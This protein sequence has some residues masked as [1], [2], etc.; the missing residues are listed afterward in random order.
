MSTEPPTEFERLKAQKDA[1]LQ[2]DNSSQFW[3][4]AQLA[5]TRL[6]E[7]L[8]QLAGSDIIKAPALAIE[9]IAELEKGQRYWFE[10]AERL[11]AELAEAKAS[12]AK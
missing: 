2:K 7:H 5:L 9:R 11:E 6:S 10:K 3:S 8:G 12:A 4:E 1:L